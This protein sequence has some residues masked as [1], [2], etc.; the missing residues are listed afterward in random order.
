MSNGS[1]CG[2]I[3]KERK[4]DLLMIKA[5]KPD[6]PPKMLEKAAV[7]EPLSAAEL[8]DGVAR[9]RIVVLGNTLR[10]E[11]ATVADSH[12]EVIIRRCAAYEG[13]KQAALPRLDQACVACETLWNAWFETLLPAAR[14][15]VQ[16]STRLGKGDSLCRFVIHIGKPVVGSAP[17]SP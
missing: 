3:Q 13:A 16:Y 2:L 6:L 11:F 7:G 1:P 10:A 14:V 12:A 4:G 15:E 5:T 17:A 8:A 9:G